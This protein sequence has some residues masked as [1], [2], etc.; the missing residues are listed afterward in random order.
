MRDQLNIAGTKN[1][2]EKEYW[3]DRMSGEL[4]KCT[5]PAD[6][7]TP[8]SPSHQQRRVMPFRVEGELFSRLMQLCDNYDYIL[9][10]VLA[11]VLKLLL[12][13]YTGGDDIIL[14]APVYKQ[15]Q[16]GDFINT[17][18]PLRSRIRDGMTF[19]DLLLQ[20]KDT[21]ARAD[22]HQ[23]YPLSLLLDHLGKE[24]NGGNFTLFDIAVLLESIHEKD[25]LRDVPLNML[26]VF[27]RTGGAILADLEYNPH[28]YREDSIRSLAARYLYLLR[29]SI[30]QV[31]TPLAEIH[32]LT[33]EEKK[34]ILEEFNNTSTHY[35]RG[36]TI[37]QL[38]EEHAGKAPH[39]IA[40]I[41]RDR[42]FTYRELFRRAMGLAALLRD[43]GVT[44]GAIVG[45]MADR[46][47]ETITGLLGILLAGG[48]Y[49]PVSPRYPRARQRYMIADTNIKLLLTAGTL[50]EDYGTRVIRLDNR[51]NTLPPLTSDRNH[52]AAGLAYVMYTSGSTGRPKAVPV[53]HRN[54]LRL[55]KNTN[56]I[57]F[58]PADRILQTGALEFDASTFE[59]WGALLNRL[60]FCMA[61]EKD[62][63]TP[64]GLK[65]A[66]E[67]YKITTL[68]L[69]SPLFNQLADA[70]PNLFSPLKNLLVGGDIV[71]PFYVEQVKTH[72][73]S[74]TIINGYG[75]TENTT[76]STTYTIR[77][78]PGEHMEQIPIGAP[79]AN[80]TAYI[81]DKNNRLCPVN[82][83]G[84]IWVG[85]D[86]LSP[87]YLNNPELTRERFQTNPYV[88][89]ERI[90]RTGDLGR[91]LPDGNIRFAGRRDHQV[92]IRGYR[93]EPD[94]I[95][96]C[97]LA[98]PQVK[99][100]LLLACSGENGGNSLRAFIVLHT[101]E[102]PFDT[103]RLREYLAQTLPNYMVPDHFT[104][105]KEMPLTP[106]GK[107]N[108]KELAQLKI[109]THPGAA[110]TAPRNQLEEKLE[111]IWAKVLGLEKIGVRQSFTHAGGNSL[112][113]I[114]VVNAV[115]KTFKIKIDI[116]DLFS[117]AATVEG[118]SQIIRGS[119]PGGYLEIEET[120][121]KEYYPVSY[122]Q[123]RLW[124]L[125]KFEPHTPAFN[126][127][128]GIT[129]RETVDPNRINL[130]L[131]QLSRRHESFRTG[132][133]DIE[134]R[135]VQFIKTAAP[136]NLETIDLSNLHGPELET[137]RRRQLRE[138][139]FTPFDL[140]KPPLVR[141]K[142][143]K[144]RE[145]EF[146]LIFA[147]S[148]LVSDGWSM[149]ILEREFLHFHETA[150]AGAPPGRLEPLR[151]QYKDFAQ[152][153]ERLLA[154]SGAVDEAARYWKGQL[155]GGIRLLNL[156]Y[157][158]PPGKLDTKNSAGYRLA[159]P[160]P[161]LEKLR[162]LADDSNATLFMIVM[163]AGTLF[164]SQITGE[165]DITIAIPGA[166]RRHD[167][168]KNV[169]GM[170]VNTL[171]LRNRVQ[172]SETFA[173]FLE[174][175]RRNTFQALKYQHY[176]MELICSQL[177][178]KYPPIKVFFNMPNIG[179]THRE[180]L[181]EFEPYHSPEVQDAKFPL[182][183]YLMEHKNA[184][185]IRCHYYK[186]LFTPLT[187]EKI[188]QRYLRILQRIAENPGKTIDKYK[189]A[190][191][192]I[193]RR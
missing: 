66:V 128:G 46:S 167:D 168:L 42:Q 137:Q 29:Q 122:A 58:N 77:R 142:L 185:D 146:D 89:G 9:F 15:E 53:S 154:G 44:P 125:H 62:I 30:R 186:E 149:E 70:D 139:T 160:E 76:F 80:S 127:T 40:L 104:L 23:N 57:A 73:P 61:D 65:T 163:A 115:H 171:L 184:I 180:P 107:I 4:E 67:K 12:R 117:Q 11:A 6:F 130:V 34:Q 113:A 110:Y 151:I 118:L 191:S 159:V 41:Y 109:E 95:N 38:V 37:G 94:E 74:V 140:E 193:E 192:R 111:R 16:K 63:L 141:V 144:C 31:D 87:G 136:V 25:Y 24:R 64:A 81:F 105:L 43:R 177:N 60:P 129:I 21:L 134:G 143:L 108:R 172:S 85:G 187:V 116:W 162:V 68:W 90:Y 98:H 55:V 132:F 161:V 28:L 8:K 86:G 93:V 153:E 97:L 166:A 173:Q 13:H 182:V 75:P 91:W 22:E 123:E 121:L 56:Y 101:P 7:G 112:K 3:L 178:I 78:F 71:S 79:I 83:T 135:P 170:F 17:V 1:I 158:Y 181:P 52:T 27:R 50:D 45:I 19:K 103:S 174:K 138:E 179:D 169:I 102:E 99:E 124:L 69:T 96:H 120:P 188:C 14:A 54:V 119:N 47:L 145:D 150:A 114:Q 164:L 72:C 59:I 190:M 49:L 36:K 183:F 18:L 152:W 126:I 10:V 131:E 100:S 165:K 175:V 155:E 26:F 88:E 92:K 84:E 48:A 20:L 189:G 82:I 5:F 39:Q 106:N 176:P 33:E 32:I 51:K 147:F 2:K 157:D 148:H 156:P 133:R 35:P